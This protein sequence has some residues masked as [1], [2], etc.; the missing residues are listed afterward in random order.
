[1]Y[2]NVTADGRY[3]LTD[4]GIR[5]LQTGQVRKVFENVGN[6][7]KGRPYVAL[8][9]PDGKRIAFGWCRL[10]DKKAYCQLRLIGI[11]GKGERQL[12][13]MKGWSTGGT[14]EVNSW[15]PDGNW[16]AA[17]GQ[18]ESGADGAEILLI[19][20]NQ[21]PTRTLP[22]RSKKYKDRFNF[23][24]DGKWLAY[25][26]AS[27]MSL[28]KSGIYLLP[29]DGTAKEEM[30]LVS[31]AN[32]MGWTPDG[33][34]VLFRRFRNGMNGLYLQP[35]QQE[36]ATGEAQLLHTALAGDMPIGVTQQGTLLHGSLNL[37]SDTWITEIDTHTGKIGDPAFR[38][39]VSRVGMTDGYSGGSAKFSPDGSRWMCAVPT[40]AILIRSM[41]AATERTI[42]PQLLQ[43]RR[44]EWSGDGRSIFIT[45][46][47]ND[48]N[49]GLYRV[50]PE[51]G[52]TSFLA[53][54]PGYT[55]VSS[56]D[57]KTIY[58]PNQKQKG[59]SAI[60]LEDGSQRLICAKEFTAAGELRLSRDGKRMAIRTGNYLGVVD[61][62]T[63]ELKDIYNPELGRGAFWGVDWSSDDQRLVA[64][65]LTWV[66]SID[67][68]S[69]LWI[70][71]AA[72]GEPIK[73][74]MH[75]HF[76]GLSISPDG[77]Y[78]AILHLEHRRQ[79]W[80]LEDFLPKV[81]ATSS[82]KTK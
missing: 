67:W 63:N 10:D 9:S 76:G 53:V 16:I 19:S 42:T 80:A 29:V 74:A 77:K 20:T 44:I 81:A 54:R 48:G 64:I 51:S 43:M 27:G 73:Q 32:I 57:G 59:I 39:E 22:T 72:G 70:F 49:R 55:F 46:D 52:A 38:T 1:M 14:L 56:S 40:N 68:S 11:D 17:L 34:G 41:N 37:Q 28:G 24:P 82:V 15:S 33:S 69:E 25:D 30:E 5:D 4:M 45:G 3:I 8:I 12:Y 65:K 35:V 60:N 21:A 62:A 23:S 75:G 31:D 36:K 18:P 78:A 61:L 58:F 13:P 7:E 6:E 66:S 71:P 26:S 2:S 79:I 47:G 50:D